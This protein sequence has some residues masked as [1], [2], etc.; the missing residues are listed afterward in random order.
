MKPA[1]ILV[2]VS[3][4]IGEYILPSVEQSA[5]VNRAQ[6]MSEDGTVATEFGFWYREANVF[7]H[8][9]EVTQTGVINGVSHYF[10][11]ENNELTRSLFAERGVYHDVRETEQYWLLEGVSI[12]N[13][14]N[15]SINVSKF[16]SQRWETNLSPALIST[17]VSVKPEKMSITELNAKI[18]YMREEGL[19]SG[20]F[21]LGFWRKVL[22]PLAT[23][24]LVFVAISFV[25]GPLRE[26][27]MGLR[28]ISGLVIGIM[29]KFF[30]DLLSPASLVFGFEPIIAI[31]LP[32]VVCAVAG[33]FLLRRAG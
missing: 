27:T 13:I 6:A 32:I 30:Q 3:L 26:A 21:E 31:L 2:L 23:I 7:M 17:E 18:D 11:D 9:E 1:L 24:S 5:R 10:Y 19:N 33:Y 8:F 20:K 28:V 14:G 29:F 12:T 4:Y 15:D 16:P 25:F 22:Q